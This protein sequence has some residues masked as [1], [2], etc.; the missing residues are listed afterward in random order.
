MGLCLLCE[1]TINY[2][3]ADIPCSG[4]IFQPIEFYPGVK[5]PPALANELLFKTK[6]KQ[7]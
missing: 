4:H 1:Y 3:F 7:S 5:T 2:L 6:N